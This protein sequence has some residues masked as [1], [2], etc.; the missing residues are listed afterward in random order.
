[1]PTTATLLLGDHL[2]RGRGPSTYNARL[3]SFLLVQLAMIAFAYWETVSGGGRI[4]YEITFKVET[5]PLEPSH[6]WLIFSSMAVYH[7]KVFRWAGF[8]CHTDSM[9]AFTVVLVTCYHMFAMFT[10]GMSGYYGDSFPMNNYWGSP[11]G[12]YS[13][14]P[15]QW[16]QILFLGL[17]CAVLLLEA[18]ADHQL[19]F[20]KRYKGGD[21][22]GEE[23]TTFFVARGD[24]SKDMYQERVC[25]VGMWNWCRHPNYFWNLFPFAF[26]ALVGGNF[27]CF[28]MWI[29]IQVF[30]AYTQSMP[31]LEGYMADRYGQDW[32]AYCRK[33]PGKLFPFL[34]I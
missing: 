31:A 10:I 13:P 3:G 33:V 5:P 21:P 2:A 16:F 29:F 17:A 20:F 34:R 1:M 23:L 6:A 24:E 26:A 7:L 11:E 32:D 14:A 4:V 28:G 19:A 22:S 25:R 18:V 30:W 15:P 9:S 8:V 27:A 12:K